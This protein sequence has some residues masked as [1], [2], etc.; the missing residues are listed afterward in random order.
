M[1]HQ[2]APM[3]APPVF[4]KIKPLPGPQR[5]SPP[6][7]GMPIEVWVSAALIWA[8]M[9]SGPSVVCTSQSMPSGTSRPKN[10]IMSVCTSASAFS[11]ISSEQEVCRT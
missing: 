10:P 6:L 7:I 4:K 8:G 5:R 1:K 3:R 11:W 9:S 2:F